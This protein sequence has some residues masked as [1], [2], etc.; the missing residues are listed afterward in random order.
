MILGSV[1]IAFAGNVFGAKILAHWQNVV[2]AIHIMAYFAF[3]IPLWVN[4]PQVASKQVGS[5]FENSGGRSSLSLSVIVGQL[6]GIYTQ[7]GVDT[8]CL[9]FPIVCC[10]GAECHLGGPHG[11]RG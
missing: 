11:R 5:G 1:G 6:S 3:I 8:V 10:R 4:A 7:V 9:R 2:F